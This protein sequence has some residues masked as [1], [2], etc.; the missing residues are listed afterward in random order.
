[1]KFLSNPCEYELIH[2]PFAL[3]GNLLGLCFT[4]Q[5]DVF[6]LETTLSAEFAILN[7][8]KPTRSH[9]FSLRG[10]ALKIPHNFKS[11]CR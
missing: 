7:H 10:I 5:I 8:P 11:R 4:Y 6:N 2:R 1:M 3:S 9:P